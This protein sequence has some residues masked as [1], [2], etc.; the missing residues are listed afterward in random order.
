MT[1]ASEQWDKTSWQDKERFLTSYGFPKG[2]S[3]HTWKYL[4][5]RIQAA[6][7]MRG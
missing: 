5:R 4:D 1:T 3:A 7:E 6:W 2:W